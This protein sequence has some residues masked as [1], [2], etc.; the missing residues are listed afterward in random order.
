MWGLNQ[1]LRIV[2][3]GKVLCSPATASLDF[4]DGGTSTIT[5]VSPWLAADLT[6][7]TATSRKISRAF[8]CLD[9]SLS[10]S[11]VGIIYK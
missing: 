2:Q 4:T 3:P 8:L 11:A 7:R 5:C 9:I 6:S 1:F 10:S